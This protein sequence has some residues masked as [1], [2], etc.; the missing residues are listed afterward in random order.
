M[1]GGRG[2]AVAQTG[3]HVQLSCFNSTVFF[4]MLLLLLLS[5]QNRSSQLLSHKFHV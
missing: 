5:L 3:A 1:N 4:L 2:L